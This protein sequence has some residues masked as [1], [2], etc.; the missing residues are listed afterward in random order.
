MVKEIFQDK[1]GG[2]VDFFQKRNGKWGGNADFQVLS[3]SKPRRAG[4]KTYH[5]AVPIRTHTTVRS[6]SKPRRAGIKTVRL[7]ESN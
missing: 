7:M 6:E 3:E 4:I 5:T 2:M 1:M